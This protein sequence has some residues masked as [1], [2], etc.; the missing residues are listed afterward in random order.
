MGSGH[1]E[2]IKE[3]LPDVSSMLVCEKIKQCNLSTLHVKTIKEEST[4][5]EFNL[6]SEERHMRPEHDFECKEIKRGCT[7]L[8]IG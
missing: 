8:S 4:R 1:A 7:R 3:N 2:E 5:C 6:I